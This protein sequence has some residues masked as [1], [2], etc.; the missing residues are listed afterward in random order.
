MT[1]C[2]LSQTKNKTETNHKTKSK[3]KNQSNSGNEKDL[4]PKQR[5]ALANPLPNDDPSQLT[6]LNTRSNCFPVTLTQIK[7]A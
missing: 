6:T 2:P 5:P 7:T 4:R 1:I 3:T